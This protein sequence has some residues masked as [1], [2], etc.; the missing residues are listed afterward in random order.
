MAILIRKRREQESERAAAPTPSSAGAARSAERA[1][2]E[3]EVVLGDRGYRVRLE[4]ELDMAAAERLTAAVES[5]ISHCR[6]MVL[7]LSRVTFLNSA[8]LRAILDL[9]RRLA[10]REAELRLIDS[11]M[12]N[13]SNVLRHAG[14]ES[15][16]SELS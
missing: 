6:S 7:D 15:L 9:Y 10:A 12:G 16:I 8:G 2:S 11:E 1:D 13:V 4:G 5:L 3:V 14:L